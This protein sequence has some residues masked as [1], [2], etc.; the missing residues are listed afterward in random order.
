MCLSVCVC[1]YVLGSRVCMLVWVCVF[2]G[3]GRLRLCVPVCISVC[4][5]YVFM[6][7]SKRRKRRGNTSHQLPATARP[8]LHASVKHSKQK[9]RMRGRNPLRASSLRS[10][11]AIN[12]LRKWCC[13]SKLLIPQNNTLRLHLKRP[14]TR[15]PLLGPRTARALVMR[16]RRRGGPA[17]MHGRGRPTRRMVLCGRFR[18]SF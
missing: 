12:P 1:V 14:R 10:P 4:R 13:F 2:V 7:A 11:A 16:R 8:D 15:N 18:E 5:I 9:S 6:Q 3:R 17:R